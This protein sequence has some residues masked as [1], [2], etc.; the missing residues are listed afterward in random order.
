MVVIVLSRLFL[1]TGFI[2]GMLWNTVVNMYFSIYI[3]KKW[4]SLIFE[5]KPIK[6]DNRK[7]AR[8]SKEMMS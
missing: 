4:F 1:V 5:L 3:L 7:A 8:V 6:G 2:L